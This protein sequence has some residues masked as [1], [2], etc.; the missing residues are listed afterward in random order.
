MSG[1][2]SSGNASF[3]FLRFSA[4]IIP[5]LDIS[6]LILD[7]SSALSVSEERESFRVLKS[8][9][10][11]ISPVIGFLLTSSLLFLIAALILSTVVFSSN[12]SSPTIFKSSSDK[13]LIYFLWIH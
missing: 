13:L 11:E 6:L 9:E 5:V 3:I 4:E 2:L 8:D 10:Y 1:Y 7:N 12:V